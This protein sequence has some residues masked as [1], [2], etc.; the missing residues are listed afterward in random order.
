MKKIATKTNAV[1]ALAFAGLLFAGSAFADKPAWAGGDKEEHGEKFG[2]DKYDKKDKQGKK[3][4]H[5]KKDKHGE[6]ANDERSHVRINSYFAEP[7]RVVVR[8]YLT[9]RKLCAWASSAAWCRPHSWT[10]RCAK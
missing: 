10:A 2:K 6:H 7:Q 8:E 1:L 4:K 5:R 9:R 3:E